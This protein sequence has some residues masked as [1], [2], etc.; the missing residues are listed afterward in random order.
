MGK[1]EYR[2]LVV[3]ANN[4]FDTDDVEGDF[5]DELN[6][7]GNDGWELVSGT[8]SKEEYDSSKNLML[9]FKRQKV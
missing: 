2:T 3:S 7:L 9:I 5:G 8:S 1:F 4:L 6:K